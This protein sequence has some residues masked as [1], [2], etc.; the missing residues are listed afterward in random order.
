MTNS[1]CRHPPPYTLVRARLLLTVEDDCIVLRA[2]G[3]SKSIFKKVDIEGQSAQKHFVGLG[4]DRYQFESVVWWLANGKWKNDFKYLDDNPANS[5]YE[6]IVPQDY[7]V[8]EAEFRKDELQKYFDTED[9]PRELCWNRQGNRNKFWNSFFPTRSANRKVEGEQLVEIFGK[10]YKAQDIYNILD[11]T[12]EPHSPDL[13]DARDFV[14]LP[15]DNSDLGALIDGEKVGREKVV[16][17]FYCGDNTQQITRDHVIPISI[18]AVSR[19]YNSRDTIPCCTNCNSILSDHYLLTVEDRAAYL[20]NRL[21]EKYAKVLRSH[22]FTERELNDFG[23]TLKSNLVSNQNMKSYLVSRILH[24][25]KIAGALYKPEEVSHL[26]GLTTQAKRSAYGILEEFLD[27]EGSQ[28]SFVEKKSEEFDEDIQIIRQLIDEK[29]HIDVGL[30]LKFDRHFPL[31]VSLKRIKKL[32][33][34]KN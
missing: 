23:Y 13:L 12:T 33:R 30:Q 21:G 5:S 1:I 34:Q 8:E 31:D 32:L 6:N 29:I 4:D 26:R 11:L 15:V 28:K 18:A 3:E 19:S 2:S 9:H 17:C 7:Q 22:D 14:E 24:C 27:F 10:F 16:S 20:A 25:H